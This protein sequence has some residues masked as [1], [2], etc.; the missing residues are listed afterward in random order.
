MLTLESSKQDYP[1]QFQQAKNE[2][3]KVLPDAEINHVGSTAVPGLAGKGIIDILVAIPDWN[4]KQATVKKIKSLGY[5]HIHPEENERIFMS[6][7]G[8]TQAGDVHLH[9]TYIGSP[10]YK[11]LLTFRDY[12]LKHP[13]KSREYGEGKVAWLR[14]AHGDRKVYNRLKS[15]WIESHLT[16]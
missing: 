8:D 3:A 13:E 7:V 2:L 10:Q 5:V 4:K 12:L 14:Q 11:L 6:R 16:E 9:L 15:K 1:Q